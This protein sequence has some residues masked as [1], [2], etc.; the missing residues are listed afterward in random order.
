MYLGNTKKKD[1]NHNYLQ[2]IK[3][4]TFKHVLDTL[5]QL[6]FKKYYCFIYKGKP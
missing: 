6:Y 2:F 1:Q 3:F 5:F 4:F